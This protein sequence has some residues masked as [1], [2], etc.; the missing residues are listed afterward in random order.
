MTALSHI[1]RNASL[2]T[3]ALCMVSALPAQAQFGGLGL[4]S[5]GR[6]SSTAETTT[7]NGCPE[8]KKKSVGASILG[9]MAGSMANRVGGRFASFVP[10]PE[11]ATILTNAIACKLDQKEQKQA[12]DAT[13]AVT[14]GDDATGAVAVGQTA[15]WTSGSRKDVKGKSTIVAV[16]SIPAVVVGNGA[17]NGKGKANANSGSANNGGGNGK[18]K[19]LASVSQCITVS[20]VVIVNGEET[21]ANKRMCKA[22]GQ[23]RYALMA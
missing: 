4:G 18:G 12:A 2:A 21:T 23:A 17:S 3:A 8:G 6:K 11:F 7:T 22:P 9:S 15:E 20:D 5:L 16:E 10:M 14:R 19:Q 1:V 13:L